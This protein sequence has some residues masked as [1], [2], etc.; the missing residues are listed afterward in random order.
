MVEL[1]HRRMIQ[2]Q[3][4]EYPE[5]QK[6]QSASGEPSRVPGASVHGKGRVRQKMRLAG[7]DECNCQA[8]SY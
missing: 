6:E 3:L 4:A 7:G 8:L 5:G 2:I 1:G